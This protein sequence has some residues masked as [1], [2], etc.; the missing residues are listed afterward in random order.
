MTVRSDNR[1]HTRL[2]KR[3]QTVAR[4]MRTSAQVLG[5]TENLSQGGAFITSPSWSDFQVDDQTEIEFFLPPTFT[6]QK[7]ILILKGPGT[8]KRVD[9]DRLGIALV[10]QKKLKAFEA[11]WGYES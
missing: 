8:V 9:E 1:R 6:G 7:D 4:I 10:F 11:S 5:T 2:S 3:F